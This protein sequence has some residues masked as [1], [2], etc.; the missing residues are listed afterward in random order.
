MVRRDRRGRSVHK[1]QQDRKE[2]PDRQVRKVKPVSQGQQETP[3]LLA[4]P[5]P[6]AN[7][8]IPVQQ[9][10]QARMEQQVRPAQPVQTAL[11]D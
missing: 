7:R 1:A 11:R 9:A 3:D 8:E 5:D 2:I 10:Q 6:R 4:L